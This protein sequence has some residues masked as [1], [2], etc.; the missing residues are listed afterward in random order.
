MSE[1]A[2]RGGV[3][4]W[5]VVLAVLVVAVIVPFV[6]W[7][8]T[9]NA[10]VGRWLA[11]KPSGAAVAAVV[12][13]ALA[14]DILLPIPSSVVATAAGS[15]LGVGWGTAAN[16]VGLGVGAAIGYALGAAGRP[17]AL[18]FVG[19]TQLDL[20]QR[21]FV[22]RGDIVVAMFR[23]VP[24]LAEVSVVVAGL[25]S[26]SVRRFAT[27]AALA[28]LGIAFAY[29]G[30]GAWAAAIGEMALAVA[31]SLVLPG[32]AIVV[33]RIATRDDRAADGEAR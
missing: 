25:A 24:V 22:R 15:L 17:V 30:L 21:L 8:D 26:M 12:V 2:S 1:P 20:A 10:A 29:A 9:V 3:G 23:P 32:V 7:E 19:Q 28:N 16:F 27:Y 14:A 33:G 31:A 4:R 5:L 18:R 13:A 11:A 6:L